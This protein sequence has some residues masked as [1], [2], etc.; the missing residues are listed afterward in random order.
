MLD[1]FCHIYSSIRNIHP[2]L[3]RIRF[4]SL[5]RV[6]TRLTANC[7][8]PAYFRLTRGNPRYRLP[9]TEKKNGVIVSFTS[10]PARIGNIW[11]VAECMLRQTRKPDRIVLWL[12]KQQFAD[13]RSL[14]KSLLHLQE[15]GLTIALR[16]NDY[17]S[18]KKY[19]YALQEYPDATVITIDDDVFYP[20]DIVERLL[21]AADS[22]PGCVIAHTAH[23]I[24]YD[25][26]GKAFPYAEW[27]HYVTHSVHGTDVFQVG[28]GGVLYPPHSLHNDATDIQSATR[29]CQNGDDIWLYVMARLNGTTVAQSG[30]DNYPLPVYNSNSSA[31]S[32]SNLYGGNDK[33]IGQIGKYCQE[34]YQSNPFQNP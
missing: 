8:L 28:I 5:L 23:Q 31:L 4:Y 22:H 16:D 3:V 29:Y 21:S 20:T 19:L 2:F 10:F 30:F 26:N 14:P 32:L 17:K 9:A 18:H 11:K 7:L 13:I 15:R 6:L 12:S 27:E 33:Q 34:H 1:F 24:R 25:S